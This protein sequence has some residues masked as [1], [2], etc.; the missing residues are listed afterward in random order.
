M[1]GNFFKPANNPSDLVSSTQDLLPPVLD[2]GFIPDDLSAAELENIFQHLEKNEF[3]D[4]CSSS[5]A[6][7]TASTPNE[8]PASTSSSF[9]EDPPARLVSYTDSDESATE[10]GQSGSPK[11]HFKKP[12]SEKELAKLGEKTF[13]A[14]TERKILWAVNL[15]RDWCF[16]RIRVP[17][18]DGRLRWCDIN[19]SRI[20]ASNLSYCLCR[21]LSEVCHADGTE[22]PAKTLYNIVIMIQMHC[23]KLG[24]TWK[25][26]NGP[27][28]VDVKNTLDNLMKQRSRQN[29]GSENRSADPISF[30][31]EDKMWREGILSEER[32]SQ[33]RDTVMFLIGLTFALCGGDEQRCLRAPGFRPQI[34]VLKDQTGRKF[35]QYTE[36]LQ[37]KSNQG[38]LKHKWMKP[39]VV[40]AFGNSNS[41]RDLVRLYE[42]Y[43][44]LLPCNSKLHKN[45]ICPG[46]QSPKVWYT[47]KP[48]GVNKV[49][50]IIKNLLK[51]AGIDG[52]FTNHSLRVT[53]ATRMYSQ[54]IDEQVI[55]EHTGYRSDAVRAYKRTDENL[56]RKAEV[57]VVGGEMDKS[58]TEDHWSDDIEI[59]DRVD[60]K[61]RQVRYGVVE[62]S[63]S[64]C[65]KNACSL[66]GKADKYPDI[67][68]IL[69]KL[70]EKKKSVKRLSLSLKV[71]RS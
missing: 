60:L 61:S 47:D 18:S 37:S 38:G 43:C 31:A 45:P 53:A 65:H 6:P 20:Q 71:K 51:S 64:K 24:K 66:R 11:F 52:R 69:K 29:M 2:G 59:I 25:L 28:F 42:K 48:L 8:V 62:G 9:K 15:F 63:G 32:P 39:K 3:P 19:D 23:D 13:A 36:D 50:E 12:V 14:S 5:T 54:G 1:T 34:E 70:D 30:E 55:K 44:S 4:N 58:Q 10:E 26:V 17:G 46:R 67:C 35:L 7:V 40:K 49:R 27:Q 16:T 56:L 68:K 22:Y 33:L 41:D 21:F 57:A